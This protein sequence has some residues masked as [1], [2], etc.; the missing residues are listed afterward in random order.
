MPPKT[1]TKTNSDNHEVAAEAPVGKWRK[2]LRNMGILAFMF[3][4]IKGLA[5]L[6]VA[7]LAVWGFWG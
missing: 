2:R 5:W 1:D 6:V 4:F 7:G 3:F